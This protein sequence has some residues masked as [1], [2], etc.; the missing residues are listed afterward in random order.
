MRSRRA[1]HGSARPLNCGVRRHRGVVQSSKILRHLRLAT[2]ATLAVVALYLAVVYGYLLFNGMP[3]DP[4]ATTYVTINPA[5]TDRFLQDLSAIASAHN[6]R[7]STGSA[8]PDNGPALHV[9]DGRGRALH[10]WAQNTLLGAHQCSQAA[11]PQ[12]DPGQFL[13]RVYPA[14]WFPVWPRAHAL[15]QAVESELE[16]NGYSLTSTQSAPCDPGRPRV[17]SPK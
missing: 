6:M 1:S 4:K 16:A 11:E 13:V 12:N 2:K 7:P 10:I 8:A 5:D 15:F 17:S 9:F 14:T 3:F